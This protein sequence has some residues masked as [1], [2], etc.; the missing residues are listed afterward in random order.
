MFFVRFIL[1]ELLNSNTPVAASGKTVSVPGINPNT[2]IDVIS[3]VGPSAS[4]D[5]LLTTTLLDELTTL[6]LNLNVCESK[7]IV[8]VK[9]LKV[10]PAATIRRFK[11]V[12]IS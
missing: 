9:E 3:R 11:V 1:I 12:S 10:A 4:I 6:I 7:D 8:V 2:F 5:M